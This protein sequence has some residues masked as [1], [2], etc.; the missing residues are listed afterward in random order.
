MKLRDL[1]GCIRKV[2]NIAI[3]DDLEFICVAPHGSKV[4]EPYL[5]REI[6]QI[7]ILHNDGTGQF[8]AD[9]LV[10]LEVDQSL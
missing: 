1:L 3:V 6:L 2:T 4:L 9:L 5:D 10:I 7:D 8:E